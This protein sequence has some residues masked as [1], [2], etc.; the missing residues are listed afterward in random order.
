MNFAPLT[1]LL[2]ATAATIA[3]VSTSLC[4]LSGC[5]QQEGSTNAAP[6]AIKVHSI[7]MIYPPE[8]RALL[9]SAVERFNAK[10]V[11]LANG[12]IVRLS[13]SSFDDLANLDKIG[14]PQTPASLW[15]AP[16]AL[17]ATA[18]SKGL[19]SDTSLTD[20]A[21]VMSSQLGVSYRPIDRFALPQDAEQIT[22]QS[23]LERPSETRAYKLAVVMGSPRFTS[24]GLLASLAT[25]SYA[26]STPLESL[27]SETISTGQESIRKSQSVIRNY[28]I[29]DLDT[30]AWLHDRQGGEPL[31]AITTRQNFKAHQRY[32]P[33]SNLQWS[34]IASPV[35]TLDYPLCTIA[36]KADSEQDM[37]S[38]KAVREFITSKEFQE[39]AASLGFEPAVDS[40]SMTPQVGT[41]AR[42]L[43]S[44]WAQIRRPS[45][46]AFVVDASIKTDRP[47]MET[48]RRE[49]KM[50]IE[51]RPSQ[52]DTVAL[53][54]ASSNPEILS[55]PQVNAE[56]L[57][58]ALNKI[59]T[60]GGNAIRDGIQTAFTMFT[61]L[62]SHNYRRSVVVFTSSKDTSSQTSITQLT[63]R[64][65]QLVGRKNV[66]LFVIALGG[67]TADFGE[68]PE[69][70]KEV[71]GTFIRSN[72]ASLP[73]DFFPIARRIQ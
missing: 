27:T 50:F 21:S 64:A 53:I 3:L 57:N 37:G 12:A 43:L 16:L 30:L 58:I 54:S 65:S 56:L 2:R 55:E 61:D 39:M 70:T 41:A 40:T 23:V 25:A 4:A 28:F 46:T 10:N 60:T 52:N 15:L 71:G 69:L 66:D 11:Q 22:I 59:S 73:A 51:S 18:S 14:T 42:T 29:S 67:P 1:S 32:T 31:V 49:V 63:S 17:L 47:T 48:I 20:C 24:S 72:I 5:N 26:T 13:A 19:P 33:Q 8:A 38:I 6:Q 34:L 35:A 36:S 68:L 62:T 44:L 45:M 7:K 9:M